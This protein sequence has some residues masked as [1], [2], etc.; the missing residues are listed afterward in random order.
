MN[1]SIAGVSRNVT[2]RSPP[3]STALAFAPEVIAGNGERR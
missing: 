2:I 1:A 3:V